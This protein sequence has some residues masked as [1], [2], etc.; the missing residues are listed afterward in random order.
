MKKI[1]AFAGSDSKTS[2][3]KQLVTYATSFIE[4]ETIKIE[5]LDLNDYQLPTYSINVEKESGFP[6]NVNKFLEKLKDADG[7]LLSLAEHNHAYTAVFKSLMDWLSRIELKFFYNKPMLLMSASPG[8]RAAIS[9]FDMATSRFPAHG[10]NIVST[11][12]F[13]SFYDNF[14]EGKVVDNQLNEDLKNAVHTFI[15]SI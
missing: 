11:Y 12:N 13:P 8:A 1:I 7:I 9:V 4:D 6:E 5:I 2:I 3:N 15:K 10:S 14:K